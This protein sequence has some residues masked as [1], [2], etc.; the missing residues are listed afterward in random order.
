MTTPSDPYPVI[1]VGRQSHDVSPPRPWGWRSWVALGTWLAIVGGFVVLFRTFWEL[2]ARGVG[3]ALGAEVDMA[4]E[5]SLYW[6]FVWTAVAMAVVAV[7]AIIARRWVAMVF[8]LLL[9][10]VGGV[11]A[12]GLYDTVQPLVAPVEHVDPGPL[13]CVCHSGGTC[14]CPGG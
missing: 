5:V 1:A 10:G 14:D 2:F 7:A 8:A 9:V 3:Q 11:L 4:A 6:T 12:L 13:P